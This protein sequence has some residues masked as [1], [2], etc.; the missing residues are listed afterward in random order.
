MYFDTH[1]HYDDE[2]FDADRD[3]LLS[4]LPEA[5]VTLVIDPGC[6]V[7]SS[8]KAIALR[9]AMISPSSSTIGRPTATAWTSYAAAPTC[10]ACFTAIPA[11][12]RWRRNS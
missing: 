2:A 11:Q 6:D 3:E 9:S 7:S 12:R 4:S 1:A 10:G 8:E 5:G